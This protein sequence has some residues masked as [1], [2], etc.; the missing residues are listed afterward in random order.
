MQVQLIAFRAVSTNRG[1]IRTILAIPRYGMI[2][3]LLPCVEDLLMEST[4]ARDD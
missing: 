3:T 1:R 4:L 2:A